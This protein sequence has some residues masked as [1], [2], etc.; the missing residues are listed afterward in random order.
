VDEVTERGVVL[1]QLRRRLN[2]VRR[3]LTPEE[4]DLALR[5][6]ELRPISPQPSNDGEPHVTNE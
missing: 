5:F 2:P 6:G 4:V 1:A 3:L